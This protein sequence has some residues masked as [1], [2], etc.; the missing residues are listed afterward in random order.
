MKYFRLV[1][2]ALF[3]LAVFMEIQIY[4][5]SKLVGWPSIGVWTFILGLLVVVTTFV[6]TLFGDPTEVSP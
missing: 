3:L 5:L 4:A 1:T 2:G 6:F